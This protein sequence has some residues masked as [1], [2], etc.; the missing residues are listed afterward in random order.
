MARMRLD[1]LEKNYSPQ[2][3]NSIPEVGPVNLEIEDKEFFVVIGPSGC[4]KT[5]LLNLIGGF[6]EPTKGRV[7]IDNERVRDPGRDRGVIF[8]STD[9]AIFPWRTVWENIEIAIRHEDEKDTEKIIKD[10]LNLVKMEGSE[11]KYPSELSGGMKQR[12]QIARTLAL[13]PKILLLDEPFAA[14]D[15]ITRDKMQDEIVDVWKKTEK[16][17]FYI[18][19]NVPEAITLASRIGIMSMGPR[20]TINHVYDIPL[21]YPR[22]ETD[23]RFIKIRTKIEKKLAEEIK[24]GSRK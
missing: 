4:G 3:P 18:T 21:D 2:E 8:Q 11:D 24:K 20:A 1:D 9:K 12:V 6:I 19:H 17:L 13:N 16:T 15:A 22:D 7:I 23:D 10:L 14:L 5:T